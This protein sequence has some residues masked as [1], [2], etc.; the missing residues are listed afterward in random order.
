MGLV[1]IVG[2]VWILLCIGGALADAFSGP[3]V[4]INKCIAVLTNINFEEMPKDILSESQ[5]IDAKAQFG[6][7][8]DLLDKM[9][10]GGVNFWTPIALKASAGQ[11]GKS[12]SIQREDLMVDGKHVRPFLKSFDDLRKIIA[13]AQE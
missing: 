2:G 8:E 3:H 10:S 11:E 13:S 12:F 6:R 9:V 4:V 7:I 1:F 5:I